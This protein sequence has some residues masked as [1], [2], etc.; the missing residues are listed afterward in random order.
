MRTQMEQAGVQGRARIGAL[1][2]GEAIG[3]GAIHTPA[4]VRNAAATA[5]AQVVKMAERAKRLGPLI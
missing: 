5:S 3:R 2:T 1:T 4:A